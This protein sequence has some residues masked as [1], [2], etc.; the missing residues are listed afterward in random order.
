MALKK[1]FLHV[2][3]GKTGSSYAQSSLALSRS[4]LSKYDISYPISGRT[5]SEAMKG[6]I[7]SGNFNPNKENLSQ[8]L[9]E[10]CQEIGTNLL[11]SNEGLFVPEIHN[12][13]LCQLKK[14]FPDTAIEILLFIRN[15]YEH[16]QSL[17]QQ[18]VKRSG[19]VGS[20]D[21]YL[22]SLNSNR[23]ILVK[24]FI[25]I[26]KEYN[27]NLTIKNYSRCK[28]FILN[29][30]ED[31]LGVKKG[32]L[33]V[34]PV[35]NVNRSL[36]LSELYLQ[37]SFNYHLSDKYKSSRFISDELCNKIP[38]LKSE[39]PVASAN[40]KS[41]FY[42][43]IESDLKKLNSLLPESEKYL[44]SEDHIDMDQDEI[45]FPDSYTFN[46]KQIDI[47][48]HSISREIIR[49]NELSKVEKIKTLLA[50]S[51]RDIAHNNY[52][53]ATVCCNKAKNILKELEF[54]NQSIINLENVINNQL[55]Q[56]SIANRLIRIRFFTRVKHYVKKILNH[57]KEKL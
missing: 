55:R 53:D 12:D 7:S 38:E 54:V 37:K 5:E 49:L 30:F 3:H 15:P 57:L 14:N 56:I 39:K 28:D 10:K 50:F 34:P 40:A 26:A 23:L 9:A 4:E 29:C 48:A 47:I 1:I 21:E 31:W 44:F 13:F 11:I 32:T 22:C 41:F 16:A 6:Y 27:A 18:I 17:Y 36:T 51:E 24:R 25:K 8:F 19:Y 33:V 52:D 42:K 46:K 20:F 2:G 43:R 35:K 45:E